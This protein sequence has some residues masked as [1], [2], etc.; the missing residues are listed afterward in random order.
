M[1][2]ITG[3]GLG[4]AAG[5]A[6]APVTLVEEGKART[7]V[8]LAAGAPEGLRAAVADL[9][10]CLERLSG[11]RLA[12]QEYR[13][14]AHGILVGAAADFPELAAGERLKELGPEG[15]LLRTEGERV[16]LVGNTALGAQHAVYLFLEKLGCRWFFPGIAWEVVPHAA[17]VRVGPWEEVQRPS[18]DARRIWYGFGMGTPVIR[19]EYADWVRRNRLGGLNVQVS[20]AWERIVPKEE[21]GAHPEWF[22]EVGGARKSSKLCTTHPEVV[23]RAIGYALTYFR[24][25]PEERM[26]SMSPSDGLGYCEC[27][28]CAA[29]GSTS[30]QVFTLANTVAAAVRAAFPDKLV[31]CLAYSAY[32]GL[33]K[34]DLE[35]NVYVQV[36]AGFIRADLTVEE[37]IERWGAKARQIGVYDYYSVWQWDWDHPDRGRANNW[38]YLAHTLPFYHRH[39]ATSINAESSNNWGPKGPGYYLAARLMWDVTTDPAACLRDFF[40]RAFGPAAPAM[41]R[42]YRRWSAAEFGAPLYTSRDLPAAFGAQW[43]PGPKLTRETL[44]ASYADLTEAARRAGSEEERARVDQ[45]RMYLH[46]LKLSL[47]YDAVKESPQA[48]AAAEAMV[49]FAAR[50][51]DTHMIHAQPLL[52]RGPERRLKWTTPEQVKAKVATWNTLTAPPDRPELERLWAADAEALKGA[53]PVR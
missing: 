13:P 27:A 45:V 52:F 42:F 7:A 21:F 23:R 48:E 14:G 51:M 9:T 3:L 46:F 39:R 31:G 2:V 11:A 20:H 44:A 6:P 35:P 32:A 30:D 36:T 28:R 16:W 34:V 10:R 8:Y 53:L 29:V 22:A 25:H 5:G 18:F 43:Q 38:A 19:Q 50:I 47:D 40:Q 24:E 15:L 1:V 12:V 17:T 4:T 49:R 26:V 41:E 33:P 37:L